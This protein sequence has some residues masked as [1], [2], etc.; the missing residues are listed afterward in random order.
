MK[1]WRNYLIVALAVAWL[2]SMNRCAESQ[3]RSE[4]NAEAMMDTVAHFINKLGTE[5]AGMKTLQLERGQLKKLV[6]DKDA[7]LKKL[8]AE[9]FAV[10]TVVKS[11]TIT[12]IDSV[13][14]PYADP[15]PCVFEKRGIVKH[16]WYGFNWQSNQNGVQI[17]SL[18]FDTET[19]AI[20]GIK[21][22]WF[23]G[24]E[25][26]TTDITNTNPYMKV[27]EIKAAEV[28]VPVPWY[29]KWY[30][31]LAAGAVGGVLMK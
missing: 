11:K 2:L 25:T 17:D 15:V 1:Q 30:V 13:Y 19:T 28:V 26:V 27:T 21:R 10:H 31:L 24:K 16:Q 18:S 4:A 14:I 5:T 6:L 23:W 29:K 3:S 12:V 7:E 8:A 22:K 9:F 20:I